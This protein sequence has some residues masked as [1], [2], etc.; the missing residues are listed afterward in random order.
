[1]VACEN[2]REDIRTATS[3]IYQVAL[4]LYKKKIISREAFSVFKAN[5]VRIERCCNL[6][7]SIEELEKAR[8]ELAAEDAQDRNGQKR[9]AQASLIAQVKDLVKRFF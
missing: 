1:M 8:R 7:Q 6:S 3:I 5:L 9:R 4:D 2:K